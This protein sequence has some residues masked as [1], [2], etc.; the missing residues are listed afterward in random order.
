MNTI[1]AGMHKSRTANSPHPVLR[2]DGVPLEQWIKG[3]KDVAGDDMTDYLVPA[4]GWLID[5]ADYD[6]A[7]HLLGPQSE[8]SATVVPVLVCADD[9]DMN[10][11]VVV[12]EQTVNA[13]TVAWERFGQ[14]VDVRHGI[15]TSVKWITPHQKAVFPLSSFRAAAAEMKRLTD[16]VW[17]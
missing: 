8:G 2:I 13:D 15:V 5:Q 4:Q 6:N 17:T 9:M 7:W 12:V 3:V 16:E 1:D 10:C 11:T 14:A